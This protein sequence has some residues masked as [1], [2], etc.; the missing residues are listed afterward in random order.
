MFWHS[1]KPKRRAAVAS[2]FTLIE[3]LVVIAIIAVLI[4]LL[5][6]AVQA[7]REAARR[8]QCTNNLKQLGIALHNYHDT[9]GAFPSSFWRA[10]PDYN[11]A[12]GGARWGHSWIEMTLPFMEQVPVYNAINFSVGV[13]GGP[14][15]LHSAMNHTAV[16]TQISTLMCPSDPSPNMSTTDRWDTGVGFNFATGAQ[17]ALGPKLSYYG[18]FGDNHPDDATYFPFQNL[19]FSRENGFGEGNTH[20]GI[21]NR[22]GG[23][24]SL[25]DITDGTSNTFAVGES[26]A[27]TCRWFTWPNP[28]GTTAGTATPINY[29]VTKILQSNGDSGDPRDHTNWRV[30][31][32]FRSSH[33][34][35]VQ[36]LFC[37]GSVK[38]IKETINRNTYRALSTRSEGEVVSADAY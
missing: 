12:P 34:G 35:I 16:T 6:P 11:L 9:M 13:A 36:F 14:G 2:G 31:F 24:T 4:G 38:S 33:P 30:G 8:S 32:G 28:N 29:K 15:G 7:A 5:L 1:P 18:C 22:S 19:P 26:I 17:L 20:T 10:T 37:D 21:M 27:Q 25:R 23:T 3:L